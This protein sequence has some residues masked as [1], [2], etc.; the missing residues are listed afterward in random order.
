MRRNDAIKTA[1]CVALLQRIASLHHNAARPE[2]VRCEMM[3]PPASTS[4]QHFAHSPSSQIGQP[5]LAAAEAIGQA[6]VIDAEAVQDRRVQVVD[7]DVILG[8]VVAVLVGAAVDD[9]ALDAAAS[10]PVGET[11]WMV[12]AAE[13]AREIALTVCGAA[14]F[15][16]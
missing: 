10:E 2:W 4:R 3:Q 13:I 7:V 14:E 11:A 15:A 16:A 6:F 12:I 5:K 8:D 9:A 1:G